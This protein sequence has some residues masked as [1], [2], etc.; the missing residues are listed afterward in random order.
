[1]C[2]RGEL[3]AC[4]G[5]GREPKSSRP[6]PSVRFGAEVEGLRLSEGLELGL[7]LYRVTLNPKP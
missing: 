7:R 4:L 2:D 5:Q 6:L 1:M 3:D